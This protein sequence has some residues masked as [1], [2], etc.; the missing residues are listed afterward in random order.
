ME[1]IN[2]LKDLYPKIRSIMF[3]G[4]IVAFNSYGSGTLI[5][6]RKYYNKI[7]VPFYIGLGN[8]DYDNNVDQTFENRGAILYE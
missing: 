7:K 2:K 3:N 1:S 8:H 4:D 5:N 6:F